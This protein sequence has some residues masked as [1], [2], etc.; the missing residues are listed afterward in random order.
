MLKRR[1]LRVILQLVLKMKAKQ[2]IWEVIIFVVVF[3]QLSCIGSIWPKERFWHAG[4]KGAETNM[5]RFPT[6]KHP[7]LQSVL[8][9]RVWGRSSQIPF[10]TK[11][12]VLKFNFAMLNMWPTCA[13]TTWKD[14][15]FEANL[16]VWGL[17]LHHCLGRLWCIWEIKVNSSVDGAG[18]CFFSRNFDGGKLVT[19]YPGNLRG[20]Q[21]SQEIKP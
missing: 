4:F 3:V 12:L 8:S 10:V 20:H 9:S 17:K 11:S 2:L 16:R 1:D 5:E 19:K 6:W 13:W 14:C 15:F 18:D 7:K 21:A